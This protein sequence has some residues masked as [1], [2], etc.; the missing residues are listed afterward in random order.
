MKK[1]LIFAGLAAATLSL[2][3]CNKEADYAGN[4]RKVEIVL[5]DVA[6]RTINYGM[7]TEWNAG[8]ELSVFNAPAGTTTWSS[9]IKFTVQD[10]SANLATGEVELTADAYDWYAFYPYT[11]Q[12][13]NPTTLNPEGSTYERSGY[14]TVGGQFQTQ[15]TDDNTEHLAG[16]NV[17]VFGNVKSVPADGTPVIEMKNAASVACFKVTNALDEAIKIISVKFTAPEDIVGTY[18]IDFSGTAP[19]FVGSGES[20]VKDNVTVT[21]S[22]PSEMAPDSNGEFY[23]VIKPFTA[24]AGAKLKVEVEAESA[25]GTKRATT[26]KEVTLSAATEFKSGFI[27]T[28]NIPFDA[29]MTSV[30][31]AT[32][33][34]EQTFG[35]GAGDFTIEDKIGSGIWTPGSASGQ[36]FMKGTSYLGGQNTEGE[37]WLVS[38]EIDATTAANG[39]KLSFHQCI[40]KYFGDVT[41]EAT[42][43]ARE[44]GGEWEQFTI[45]YPTLGGNWSQ[46][47]EQVVDLSE[48]KGKVFQFAFKYVGH[49]TTAGTWEINNVSVD[50]AGVTPEFGVEQTSFEVAANVTSVTVNVTGN[51]DWTVQEASEG[52]TAAPTSGSGAGAI[53]VSFPA[54]TT[55][56]EKTY[57]LKVVTD[58]AALVDAGEEEFVID[59]TQAK[60]VV[61]TVLFNETFDQIE[62]TGGRDGAFGGQVA[63]NDFENTDETWDAH[64]KVYGAS[65]CAKYGTSSV[66]GSMTTRSITLTG[67]AVL[68]FSAAGW[69][70]GTNT[71]TVTASG[72]TLSGNTS[73]TLSNGEW[74]EYFVDITGVTDSFTLTFTGKRGFIDDVKVTTE[75]VVPPVEKTL[76][77]I[78][79]SGQKTEFTVGEAFTHD[80]AVVTATYSDNS[81]KDVTASAT[82][83]SPD[84][85]SAGTKTV[86]VSYTEGTA[87]KTTSYDITVSAASTI[88]VSQA[89]ALADDAAA[90]VADAIVAA[91]C[92]KGFIA[93]DGTQ[94]IYVF[95]NKQPTVAL[96]DKVS[97]SAVK[98]T[99]YGLPE[100]KTVTN[101]E[102]TSH[103]N[104]IPRTALTDIT[105][106]I[107]TYTSSDTDYITVT[108]TL[109][110]DGSYYQVTV[111][112][113]TKYASPMYLYGID[114]SALV[115]Q[116]VVL[117]GYFNTVHSKGYVQ[118]IA[119]EIKAAD[120]NVKYCT[121]STEALNVAAAAQSATFTIQAN[122]AWT[123]SSDNSAFTVSPA[124]GTSDATVTVSFSANETSAAR[125]ANI[126]VS[127]P[128]A[129]VTKTVV[130]TQAGKASEEKTDVLKASDLAAT[131]TS[132]TNFSGVTKN[133]G[134]V[135]AGNSAKSSAGAI[136][137]RSNNSNS[138]IVS[139]TSGGK[140]KSITIK[141]ESGDNTIDV[142]GSNTAYT[143]ASDLYATSG[144]TNQGTKIGSLSATGTIT[145]SGDYQ[146]VGIRS[147]SGAVYISEITI[148]WE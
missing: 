84:M 18:Y 69:S 9:N 103:E 106:T 26:T 130:L 16:K 2:V 96:G 10:A 65:H 126:T 56:T 46:F 19:T 120:A 1:S 68:T 17:P 146:Y 73:I 78:A 43:W 123:V 49:A 32:L 20:Y 125:V 36:T 121:V 42:L 81:T 53:T 57:S 113:A 141:V 143:A 110:K 59:I 7:S 30:T 118:V 134:A 90:N 4:G 116:Q 129:S 77:S 61:G 13:P 48:F 88:T 136:Q 109:A 131:S 82:F 91:I 29:P 15:K 33:P 51:V 55:S 117:T 21:N 124:S 102:V 99:Y 137:L 132:Y 148:E 83:S 71:L 98:T 86:T 135:Y 35:A 122:A 100:L 101:M 80:T 142:Y 138:G 76:V 11:S 31:A 23:A 85:A 64:D 52:V 119:T 39:V 97:F 147:Y 140:L 14:V 58:N 6:T 66:N 28:L 41:Q 87:T 8:D 40:N 22:N 67:D 25:D 44:K 75:S 37:S 5:S 63:S 105:S 133:S 70:S 12:I 38:P 34:Y 45:T 127:C 128:D 60:A 95:E 112:G 79:V 89:C 50:D 27:K 47:E 74:K 24:A 72:A 111:P 108:G 62:G 93:T 107:D 54:N 3:G 139:T 114:P 94:N 144:N 115:G 145:V 104:A 92:T